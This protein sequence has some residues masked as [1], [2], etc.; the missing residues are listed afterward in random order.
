LA[1]A[2][3]KHPPLE[4]LDKRAQPIMI[5][6]QA[7]FDE[8]TVVH[9]AVYLSLER[10]TRIE[11]KRF[12]T[13]KSAACSKKPDFAELPRELAKSGSNGHSILELDSIERFVLARTA[14]PAYRHAA[15]QR[16]GF[17]SA[18]P[19]NTSRRW[20]EV[21]REKSLTAS[22]RGIHDIVAAVLQHSGP[23]T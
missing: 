23:L 15:W 16:A 22:G 2:E 4:L 5:P 8:F 11:A 7:A 14:G 17:P 3:R 6:S 18:L 9:R 21:L 10:D 13:T 20:S 12:Q 1:E 19:Y